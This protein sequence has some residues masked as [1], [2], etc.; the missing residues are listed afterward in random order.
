M[1][2]HRILYFNRILLTSGIHIQYYDTWLV[3]YFMQSSHET[4][5][6]LPHH[7]QNSC[8]QCHNMHPT[9]C[10]WTRH[11]REILLEQTNNRNNTTIYIKAWRAR[12]G[13]SECERIREKKV[14]SGLKWFSM[15]TLATIIYTAG[16]MSWN[17]RLV[18]RADSSIHKEISPI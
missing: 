1:S 13:D 9:Q 14:S 11:Q 6:S 15:I 18:F 16:W 2:F 3:M 5:P 4:I 10:Q 12:D 7:K 8:T 17:V